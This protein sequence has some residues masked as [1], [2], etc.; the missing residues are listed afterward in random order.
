MQEKKLKI[1]YAICRAKSVDKFL[2]IIFEK[3]DEANKKEDDPFNLFWFR[4]EGSIQY[5][6]LILLALKDT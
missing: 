6:S 3:I 5:Y 4:G 2:R 1:E